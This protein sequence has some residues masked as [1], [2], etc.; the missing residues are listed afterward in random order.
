MAALFFAYRFL[1]SFFLQFKI[2]KIGEPKTPPPNFI[3]KSS[4][5]AKIAYFHILER[6]LSIVKIE[7]KNIVSVMVSWHVV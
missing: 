5:S 4:D 7:K 2:I 1:L 6:L 3:F